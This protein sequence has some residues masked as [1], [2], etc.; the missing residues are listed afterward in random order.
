MEVVVASEAGGAGA[1]RQYRSHTSRTPGRHHSRGNP[2]DS[3]IY[4]QNVERIIEAG[5]VFEPAALRGSE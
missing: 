3:T 5:I 4:L 2:L 1:R